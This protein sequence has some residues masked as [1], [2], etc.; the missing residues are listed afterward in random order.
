MLTKAMAV[1]LAPHGVAVNAIGPGYF[2]TDLTAALVGNEAFN[3]WLVGRTPMRRWGE[4]PELAPAA[5]F[6]ASDAAS[7]ITGHMLV[8][9]GGLTASM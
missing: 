1:D 2:R 7:F 6:L 5:V 3:Q 8:V 4:L 9:D